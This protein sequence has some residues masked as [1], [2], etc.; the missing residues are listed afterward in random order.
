M[1]RMAEST[2]APGPPAVDRVLS[3][4]QPTADSFHIGN[5]LGALRHWVALQ[6]SHEAF[7]SV[8]DQ[9]AITVD[10]DPAQLRQ[11]TLVS[12]AQLLAL[13]VDPERSVLFVQ[14][15]VPEHA[16]LA[17][18]LSCMT[19][20]GEASRMTQF[21]DKSA[22]H[23]T[24]SATVGLFT[25]P[26]LMAAD[27]LI[28]RA[29]GVPVGED[30]RQHLELTR[31]L[32]QR[33]N[34]RYG[35]TFVVPEP[36]IVKDTAKIQDLQDPTAKMS[37][38]TPG[39]CIF[40]LDPVK[41]TAKKIKSAVTDSET[42]VRFDPVNKPGVSNLLTMAS[43]F[44]GRSIPDLERHYEG[45]MYGALKGDVADSVVEFATDYQ[46]KTESFLADPAH[47]HHI[48][49]QGSSKAREVAALTLSDVYER[50]GFVAI[51]R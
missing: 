29:T 36:L 34:S 40:L 26:I 2:S 11:R 18:V 4:I 50:V 32:A 6:D 30:Q 7:Y 3:G 24:S 49:A 25:Y 51:P 21:K 22:R 42:Q 13:G 19:G 17:W 41:Q 16:Q 39:G 9:H 28:Y 43:I 1:T 10:Q 45:S 15:Q 44:T 23:G 35:P 46:Q 27:I 8:V 12:V 37:K 14:S 5:Y 38:S 31:G 48:I 33:F 47:L 20:Y